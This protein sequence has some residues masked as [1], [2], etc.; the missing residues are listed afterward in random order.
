MRLELI[1]DLLTL[2]VDEFDVTIATPNGH[3][4]TGLIKLAHMCNGIS[5]I[6]IENLLHHADVPNFDDAIRVTG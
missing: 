3:L 4:L 2:D 1:A 5:G 6:N